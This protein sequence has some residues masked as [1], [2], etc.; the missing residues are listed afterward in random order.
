MANL[1]GIKEYRRTD[2]D[3]TEFN[4]RQ[5]HGSLS[6]VPVPDASLLKTMTQTALAGLRYPLLA[7]AKLP[8]QPS[9][10]PRPVPERVG[11]PSL[12]HHVVYI[13]KENRTYDQVLGD[14]KEGMGDPVL[15]AFG[16]R[17]TPNQHKLVRQFVLLDNTYCCGSRSPDGHQWADSAIATDYMER[18]LRRISR[19]VIHSEAAGTQEDAL[20]YSCSAGFLWDDAIA[21][22]V[23]LRDYGEFTQVRKHWK[24]PHRKGK[25]AFSRNLPR[26]ID[27]N[28]TKDVSFDWSDAHH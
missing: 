5:W 27:S 21:H 20:A 22:G 12:I 13:I 9:K 18:S 25:P 1:K 24:D 7:Q 28:G 6:M 23:S 16:E 3:R 11:E 8:P 15:C 17:V 14:V 10:A 19:A 2:A 26:G 4:S